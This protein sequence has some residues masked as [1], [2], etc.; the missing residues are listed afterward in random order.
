MLFAAFETLYY[1]GM[2]VAELTA[3]YKA[4]IDTKG[5]FVMDNKSCQTIEGE[6]VITEP[7]T[8]RSK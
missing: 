4:D 6:D 3:L 7:K 8:T 5:G 2:R 1:T